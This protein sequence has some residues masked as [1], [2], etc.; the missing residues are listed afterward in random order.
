MLLSEQFYQ[1]EKTGYLNEQFR[2]FHLKDQTRK[3]FS[4]HYHDF[5]KVVIF[6]SGKAAYHIEGKAY[7]LKP[8]D[9]LLVNR[10]AIH[11][12]EI[13]PSVPYE[14]FILW[15]QNDIPW[16]ELLKCFQKANDRSFSLIRLDTPVEVCKQRRDDGRFPLRSSTARPPSLPR[17]KTPSAPSLPFSP[18][19]KGVPSVLWPLGVR[20]RVA[21]GRFRDDAFPLLF[22]E[23]PCAALFKTWFWISTPSPTPYCSGYLSP[24]R[25]WA[26]AWPVPWPDK[27]PR[28]PVVCCHAD[29]PALVLA[30]S[31]QRLVRL[32]S[33]HARLTGIQT[34]R[35]HR[36]P[37]GKPGRPVPGPLP[38]PGTIRTGKVFPGASNPWMRQGWDRVRHS[39]V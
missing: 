28:S 17:T 19:P 25:P 27:Y 30:F 3:E 2:L 11:R 6:I 37:S 26:T 23:A 5:H 15:I 36:R 10:H 33:P 9:I 24:W 20:D 32:R 38:L 8:W 29:A 7:Q 18:W 13:D 14:R 16:Q 21:P 31:N 12:P 22:K 1:T 4:Y 35:H 34:A 39:W